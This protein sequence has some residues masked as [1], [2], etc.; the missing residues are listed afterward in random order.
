M[1][2]ELGLRCLPINN[3]APGPA[4]EPAPKIPPTRTC[5]LLYVGGLLKSKGIFVAAQAGRELNRRG[6]LVRL[7]I[8]GE[9]QV[10]REEREFT[11]MYA[12]EIEAGQAILVGL[13]GETTKAT[14][15]ENAHVLLLPTQGTEGQPLVIIEAMS[16]GVL[17]ITTDHGAIP[18]LLDFPGADLLMRPGHHDASNIADTIMLLMD[19]PSTY[20]VLSEACRAHFRKELN[21]VETVDR[22][23][24]AIETAASW[25]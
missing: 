22:L 12:A 15:F 6:R 10:A 16:F 4:E 7:T 13:V 5:N 18:D 19:N 8:A 3:G 23:L 24:Q 9:W 14:L 11:K 25:R 1:S 2:A 17:P 21:F 20:G